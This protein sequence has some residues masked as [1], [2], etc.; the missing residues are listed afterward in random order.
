MQMQT[1]LDSAQALRK[2]SRTGGL[3]AQSDCNLFR[4]IRLIKGTCSTSNLTSQNYYVVG[5]VD[6]RQGGGFLICER[7]R[8]VPDTVGC[9]IRYERFVPHLGAGEL[10]ANV[11]AKNIHLR[12]ILRLRVSCSF[13]R[14]LRIKHEIA[15]YASA[16]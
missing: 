4:Q 5:V 7:T 11:F 2:P 10:L 16:V 15:T 13:N 1:H 8:T 14:F 9:A 3:H 12:L 6:L